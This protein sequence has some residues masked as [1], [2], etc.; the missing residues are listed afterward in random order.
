[1]IEVRSIMTVDLLISDKS[2]VSKLCGYRFHSVNPSLDQLD[3]ESAT[4]QIGRSWFWGAL[5][6][7]PS[8]TFS[9]WREAYVHAGT[10]EVLCPLDQDQWRLYLMGWN[11]L[12]TPA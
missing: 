9:V 1:M 6:G 12:D 10:E 3:D 7:V 4:N 2:S 8:F 11:E 5:F